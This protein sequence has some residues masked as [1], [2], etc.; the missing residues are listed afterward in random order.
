[1]GRLRSAG[2]RDDAISAYTAEL[3]GDARTRLDEY[4]AKLHGRSIFVKV[5]PGDARV[6]IPQQAAA[7]GASLIV[8]GKQGMSWLAESIVGSVFEVSYRRVAGSGDPATTGVDPATVWVVPR[9]RG[10][11]HVTA[12]TTL[13][14]DPRDPFVNGI[15]P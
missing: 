7:M 2:V 15:R 14:L 9:I 1:M 12:E 6:L 8:M 10:T 3:L 11:A 4:V 5:E 13:L